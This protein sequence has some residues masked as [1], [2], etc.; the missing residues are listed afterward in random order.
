MIYYMVTTTDN[1]YDYFTQFDE[2]YAFDVAAGYHTLSYLARVT[3][4]SH[5]LSEADQRAAIENALDEIVELN[6]NG[7]YKLVSF[8][9]EENTDL[10]REAV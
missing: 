3:T 6:I 7:M 10:M 5:D 4:T 2:W 9:K 1:P 8:E